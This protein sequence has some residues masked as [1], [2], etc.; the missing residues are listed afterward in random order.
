MDRLLTRRLLMTAALA[1]VVSA[2]AGGGSAF[3]PLRFGKPSSAGLVLVLT[4]AVA[5]GVMGSWSLALLFRRGAPGADQARG[6]PLP[7]AT[8]LRR[9]FP[10]AVAMVAL[11]G[12][13]GI[14]RLNL[15]IEVPVG[16]EQSDREGRLGR[17]LV[18]WDDRDG[19]VRASEPD[20]P[21]LVP[22]LDS[23]A[24]PMAAALLFLVVGGAALA[25][26][27][28]GERARDAEAGAD[29]IDTEAARS[30]VLRSIEAML[31][32]PDP[33]TAIIGAYALLLEGLATSGVPRWDYEGPVEHLRRALDHLPV[34]SGPVERLVSLFQVARF[35]T[36]ALT[37]AH[38]D[39]ALSALHAVAADLDDKTT[40]PSESIRLRVRA[41]GL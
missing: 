39:E 33:S 21:L 17:P 2:G 40:A 28:L 4:I 12:L 8:A 41:R 20:D 5:V 36:Q 31:S 27:L 32:D 16:V 34:R 29:G 3:A 15:G 18:F 11:V 26:W 6:R 10:S 30:T 19:S 23:R 35:S 38:R 25:W 22:V 14:A 24:V 37:V 7:S 9:A 13:L 1:G